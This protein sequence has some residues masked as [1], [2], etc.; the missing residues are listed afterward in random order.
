MMMIR[1]RRPGPCDVKTNRSTI[2]SDAAFV[3]R[4]RSSSSASSSTR[5]LRVCKECRERAGARP[6]GRSTYA[7]TQVAQNWRMASRFACDFI[8]LPFSLSCS[9]LCYSKKSR[10]DQCTVRRYA[11]LCYWVAKFAFFPAV[12]VHTRRCIGWSE[13]SARRREDAV[14]CY[15]YAICV[16][17]YIRSLQKLLDPNENGVVAKRH[18]EQQTAASSPC[19]RWTDAIEHLENRMCAAAS[20]RIWSPYLILKYTSSV[21]I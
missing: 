17:W 5:C 16:R 3:V 13:T 21:P 15:F 2:V 20:D 11:V 19:D 10:V 8:L 14:Q 9:V 1:T 6:A 12:F 7:R 18:F 4:R